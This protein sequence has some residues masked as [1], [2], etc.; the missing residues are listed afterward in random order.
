[1]KDD[2]G[3]RMKLYEQAEA[4]R[5]ATPLLPVCIRLDGK[6]F[7]QWTRGLNHPYDERL[8]RLMVEVTQ[9]LVK[10]TGALVGYTQSDEI[11]LVLY[12]DDVKS[13]LYFH[14]KFQK[15]ASVCAA[16]A[17]ALFNAG[18]PGAIPEKEGLLALFDCRVWT[19]PT[20]GEAANVFLWREL[21]AT[22]N[23]VSMAARSVYSH[24]A[25]QN[26]SRSDMMDLLMEKGINWNDYPT[27]F[28]RGT[29]IKRVLSSRK[30]TSDEIERLPIKHEAR[31]NPDLMVERSDVQVV[32]FPPLPKVVDRVDLLFGQQTSKGGSNDV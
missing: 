10:T 26:K 27:F 24:K 3:D 19:V 28:K 9:G 25:L 12:S 32:D 6:G 8:S 11:S 13:D 17:T 5:M 21:D 4:G 16:Q 1:M 31:S 23:S 20:L 7:S 18:V 15:L 14:G 22:K 29:Y 30:F 2:L